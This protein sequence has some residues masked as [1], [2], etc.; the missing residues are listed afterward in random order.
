[1]KRAIIFFQLLFISYISQQVTAQNYTFNDFVGTW[2][3]TISSQTNGYNDPMTMIIYEDHFYTETSGHLMPTIYPN[4]QQCDY[5]APTNSMHWW[6]LQ[7]VYAGMHFYTHVYYEVVYFEN[8]TLIMHY[9]FWDDPVP[10]PEVGTIYL[11]KENPTPQPQNLSSQI[12]SEQIQLNWNAP[13]NI[14]QGTTLLGYKVYYK[15]NNNSFTLLANVTTT[16]YT[17]TGYFQAGTHT[18]YVTA[19]YNTGESDPSNE[20]TI[21]TT[22]VIPVSDFMADNTLPAINDTVV[23]TDLSVHAPTSWSWSFSPATVEYL[24]GTSAF[25]QHPMVRFTGA[26]TYSVQLTVTNM[27]GQDTEIKTDYI[28]VGDAISVVIEISANPVC[29]GETTQLSAM[30]SGGSG[31]YSYSWSSVPPGFTSSDPVIEVA[32][33]VTTTYLVQVGEGTMV[34]NDEAEIIV[35]AVPEIELADWPEHLCNAGTSPVQL[36]ALPEGGTFS[37][38]HVTEDGLFDP[39]EADTGWNVI[40]YTFSSEQGCEASA[41]DS[42]YVDNCSSSDEPG[43]SDPT[44]AV[45]PNPAVD[46][47]N[48]QSDVEIKSARIINNFGQLIKIERINSNNH[49]LSVNDLA[50]GLYILI[51]DTLNGHVVRRILVQK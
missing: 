24:Q 11:V 16:T 37:G 15:Y 20:T 39:E 4:T 23:F 50:N 40:T 14:P 41:I 46:V 19:V 5:D 43:G 45:Y 8:D 17:H 34:A 48:I 13:A 38:D 42:I 7:T 18:Y 33:A 47:I 25:S 49:R 6:W 36:V 44:I 28:S 12:I 51:L 26:G 22:A 32:P 30:V 1:M 2:N 31:N 10:H 21:T 9:N 27:A 29:A 35:N 3:G